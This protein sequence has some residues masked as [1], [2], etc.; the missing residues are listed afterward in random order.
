MNDIIRSWSTKPVG[1]P[2]FFF[3]YYVPVRFTASVSDESKNIQ[4][5]V[6]DFKDGRCQHDIQH[7]LEQQLEKSFNDFSNTA[8]VCIPAS[9]KFSNE[10]RYKNFSNALC[11]KLGIKNAF[12]HIKIIKEKEPSHLGG[13]DFAEFK[14]DRDF[15]YNKHVILFDDVVT[16]GSSMRQ[17]IFQ[18][19]SVGATVDCCMSFARTYSPY[20][21]KNAVHPWSNTSV[22][23]GGEFVEVPPSNLLDSVIDR[24]KIEENNCSTAIKC[25]FVEE[26]S[27]NILDK[28]TQYK[29]GSIITFGRF[30]GRPM[31]WIVL[32]Q[33]NDTIQAITKYGLLSMAYNE[34]REYTTWEQCS[35]RKWLNTEFIE[36]N[37]SQS[38]RDRICTH[39]VKA[40]V[41][42]YHEL[43]PGNDTYD[44]AYL[45]SFSEY[46][47]FFKKKNLFNCRM[48]GSGIPR[49]CW[50]RDYGVDRMHASFI[51][52]SGS[53]HSGGSWVD[54]KR[55]A[56]RPIMWFKV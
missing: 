52:R 25:D 26:S 35:L 3:F 50:L 18:L 4:K 40:E 27:S 33:E 34:Q 7:L 41:N 54:S 56:V 24:G 48:L 6:W 29:L 5:L 51:G 16:T 39:L 9:T 12:E 30:A 31:E 15:F 36:R 20:F 42:E 38:E 49:Q 55:N 14:L 10:C 8:F 23:A 19:Q 32:S 2:Y 45:L 28:V 43:N 21:T 17:F 46:Q 11:S 53:I 13:T 47:R 1:K 44:K 37:F 22:V